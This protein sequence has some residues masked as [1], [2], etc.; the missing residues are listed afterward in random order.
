ML[1]PSNRQSENGTKFANSTQNY[2]IL[3]MLPNINNYLQLTLLDN[4]NF[5]A[6]TVQPKAGL[7]LRFGH[8]T[9]LSFHENHT[10]WEF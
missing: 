8:I 10:F 6:V 7:I 1:N 9:Q 4:E 3:P 2:P 5:I